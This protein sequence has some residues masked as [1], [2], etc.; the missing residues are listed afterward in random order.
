MISRAVAAVLMT[1]LLFRKQ[2]E[3]HLTYL[4]IFSLKKEVTVS[5]LRIAI[6]N[7]LENGCFALGRVLVTGIVALFGTAQIAVFVSAFLCSC[8]SMSCRRMHTDMP[9]F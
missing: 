2:Y 7:G 5:I 9:V 6:P 3:V 1:A 8:N 4:T